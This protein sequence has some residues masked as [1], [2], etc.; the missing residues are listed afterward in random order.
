[1][2]DDTL[3]PAKA[4]TDVV[5][6]AAPMA[7]IEDAAFVPQNLIIVFSFAVSGLRSFARLRQPQ[8]KGSL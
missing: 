1:V 2:S 5:S 3:S 6:T 8:V 4:G 7:I